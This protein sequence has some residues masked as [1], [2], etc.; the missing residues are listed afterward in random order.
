P[1]RRV[2]IVIAYLIGFGFFAIIQTVIV[3]LYSINVLDIVIVGSIWNV[4]LINLL[5]ALV[6]LSL[7]ILLSTFAATEF[8]MIQFIP[9]VIVLQVFFSG[10]FSLNLIADWFHFIYYF[11]PIY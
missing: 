2:E 4:M 7:G 3:V 6:A 5:L 10:I 9:V 11:F 8:Q 1:I